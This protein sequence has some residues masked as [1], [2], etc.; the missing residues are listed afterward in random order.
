MRASVIF[1]GL[2]AL[3]IVA[4]PA[5]Y[6]AESRTKT[7]PPM[8]WFNLNKWAD[9][10]LRALYRYV[11]HLQPVGQSAPQALPPEQA[12]PPPPY[13]QWPSPPKK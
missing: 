7:R 6:G 12:P 4:A 2:A 8:P 5:A 3:A 13:I 11:R 9:R 1:L 10:D